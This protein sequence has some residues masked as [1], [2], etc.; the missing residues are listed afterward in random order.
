[1]KI[2]VDRKVLYDAVQVVA[3]VVPTRS[4][5]PI[6]QNLK[7]SIRKG[8]NYLEATDTE[9]GLR[10]QLESVETIEPGDVLIP[11][12]DLVEILKETS[13]ERIN[14]ESADNQVTIKTARSE[15][16]VLYEDPQEYP[17]IPGFDEKD[18]VSLPT[19]VLQKLVQHVSFAV[20]TEATRYAIH[21]VLVDINGKNIEMVGTDGKRLAYAKGKLEQSVDNKIHVIASTKGLGYLGRVLGAEEKEIKLCIDNNQLVF[22]TEKA[23]LVSIMVEGHFPNYQDVIPKNLTEKIELDRKAFESNLRKARLMTTEE[24]KAV[25]LQFDGN[26][27]TLSSR[28]PEKGESRIEMDIQYD[29]PSFAVGF[30]P[31][32]LLDGLKVVNGATVRMEL[33]DSNSPAVLQEGKEFLY[34]VMPISLG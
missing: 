2:H 14:I 16:R 12:R 24:S 8:G 13:D 10:Y 7:I 11:A 23:T 34:V 33:K 6:L 5:K 27:L 25:R 17:A 31:R 3:G 30:D 28:A 22:K 26:M 1:M 18:S 4:T 9:I 32:F 15:F 19:D 21:G 20:A 29:G